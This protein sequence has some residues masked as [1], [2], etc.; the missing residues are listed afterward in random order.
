MLSSGGGELRASGG[1]ADGEGRAE[2]SIDLGLGERPKGPAAA[3]HLTECFTGEEGE[4]GEKPSDAKIGKGC[5][6]WWVCVGVLV[7]HFF[8][9]N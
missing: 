5:K 3:H 6:K 9:I 1:W 2:R 4:K 7:V 8:L